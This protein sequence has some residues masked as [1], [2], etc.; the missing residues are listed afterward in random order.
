MHKV[1]INICTFKRP[2][3][4][5]AC[6]DSLIYQEIPPEWLIEILIVDNDVDES[7]KMLALSYQ[8]QTKIPISY[9]CESQKGIPFA[10]NRC[11]NESLS[12]D[13]GWLLFIDDDET[14]D[15]YW[16]MSYYEATKKYQADVFTG[17]VNYVHHKTKPLWF[18]KQEKPF[19]DGQI[20]T[21]AAT[22]NVLV[23][24]KVFE[25]EGYGLRFDT[26]MAF[27]GGSDTEIFMRL[28]FLGGKILF[29]TK[30]TVSEVVLENR[31]NIKWL[32]KREYRTT[33]NLVYIKTNLYGYKATF[34]KVI[35]IC[36]KH[37]F[38]GILGFV[39]SPVALI[40]GTVFF[41]SRL[42]QSARHFVKLF[43]NI[44]GLLKIY[45]RP[46]IVTDGY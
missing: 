35:F 24:K 9:F 14:A 18:P 28:I 8:Q 2:K 46:Y 37:L 42:Y 27:S 22:N 4:L 1:T 7:A 33:N 13:A 38:H 17:P 25:S 15:A 19:K 6:L 10:R 32:I 31:G 43:A 3:M 44:A 29:V 23:S 30:A 41:K 26:N 5:K 45:V 36:F 39:F 16:L 11:C 40:K 34:K 21:R 20:R 12:R